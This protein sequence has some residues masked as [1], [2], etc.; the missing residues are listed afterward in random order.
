MV[1]SSPHHIPHHRFTAHCKP[2]KKREQKDPTTPYQIIPLADD[3]ANRNG[4]GYH[5]TRKKMTPDDKKRKKEYKWMALKANTTLCRCGFVR[6][7]V[8]DE[9]KLYRNATDA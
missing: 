9:K 5:G 3:V 4:P 1:S 2:E 7:Y 6:K 8:G